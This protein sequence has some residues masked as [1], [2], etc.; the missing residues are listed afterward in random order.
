MKVLTI[1]VTHNRSE[2]LERCLDW[3]NSQSDPSQEVLV[4]N[5]GSTDNTE[6]ILR[7]KIF[8]I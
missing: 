2:L 8:G 4:I 1:V 5:N 7:K 6:E 3:I